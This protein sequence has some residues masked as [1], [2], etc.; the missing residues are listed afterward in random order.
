MF[1]AVSIDHISMRNGITPN[2][3]DFLSREF[4]CFLEDT[5][6]YENHGAASCIY[7]MKR[8]DIGPALAYRFIRTKNSLPTKQNILTISYSIFFSTLLIFD[9]LKMFEIVLLMITL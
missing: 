4:S 5:H 9:D 2:F 1:I 7:S 3:M 6:E 8:N